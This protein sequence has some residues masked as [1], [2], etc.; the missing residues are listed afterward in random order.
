MSQVVGRVLDTAGGIEMIGCLVEHAQRLARHPAEM[1]QGIGILVAEA[2][3]DPDLLYAAH[4]QLID[5]LLAGRGTSQAKIGAFLL[6]VAA[7]RASMPPL[8]P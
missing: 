7:L 5:D 8:R 4:Q 2:A 6:R 1:D 3:N